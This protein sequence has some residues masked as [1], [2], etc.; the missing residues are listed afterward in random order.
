MNWR[1]IKNL[2]VS[3]FTKHSQEH[4][5]SF[6]PRF[7]EFYARIQ[8]G[9]ARGSGPLLEFWQKCGY[10]IGEWDRFDIAH[11]TTFMLNTILIKC[12]DSVVWN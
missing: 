8:S 10:R 6:S 1:P 11:C 9:G 3:I 12:V 4:P 7:R 2:P 5:L